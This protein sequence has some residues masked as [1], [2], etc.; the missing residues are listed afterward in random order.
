MRCHPARMRLGTI[1]HRQ[2]ALIQHIAYSADGKSIVTDGDDG[3]IRVWDAAGGRLL[4]QIAADVGAISDFALKS[5]SKTAMVTGVTSD[6]DDGIMR[7]VSFLEL[8]T[9]HKVAGSSWREEDPS[10][11]GGTLR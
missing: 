7:R 3:Q 2:S 10:A 4:R 1:R 6:A 8:T 9:G 5:D 11:P